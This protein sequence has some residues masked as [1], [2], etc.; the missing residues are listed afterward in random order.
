MNAREAHRMA[1]DRWRNMNHVERNQYENVLST[2]RGAIERGEVYSVNMP[3]RLADSVV[4]KLRDEG[5][6]VSGG[7]DRD[8][9]LLTISWEHVFNEQPE[10]M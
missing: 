1:K 9:Y 10:N 4:K 8:G 5:Y 6:D 7:T 2:I 3:T